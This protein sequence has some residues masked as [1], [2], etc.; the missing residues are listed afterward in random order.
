M[1]LSILQESDIEV[2]ENGT[3]DLSMKKTKREGVLP[4]EPSSSSSS[5][6][7]Q[8]GASV[9]QGHTQPEWEEPLDFTK[10]SGLK[11]EDHEEVGHP[12]KKRQISTSQTVQ[13]QAS[14]FPLLRWSIPPPHTPH[15]MAK[16]R[17]RTTWRTGSTPVRSPPAASRS[18]FSPK[19]AKRI[20]LCKL[21]FNSI[22]LSL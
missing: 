12:P 14:S 11:E 16:K 20:F 6:S 3:L 18:S 19:R 2:D 15:Q 5:S 7:Q 17:I 4:A 22:I 1:S 9:S 21:I 13:L 10:Q 8:M